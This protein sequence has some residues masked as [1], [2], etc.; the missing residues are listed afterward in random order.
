VNYIN[1]PLPPRGSAR[2]PPP[3]ARPSPAPPPARP[4]PAPTPATSTT[5]SAPTQPFNIQGPFLSGLVGHEVVVESLGGVERTGRLVA[6]DTYSVIVEIDGI[7]RL[8]WKHALCGV[9]ARP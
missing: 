5:P 1:R 7:R 4:S 6:F 3:P 8:I 9:M 2:R